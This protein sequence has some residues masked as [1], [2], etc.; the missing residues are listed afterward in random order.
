MLPSSGP[1]SLITDSRQARYA[2]IGRI[3]VARAPR[4][5]ALINPPT[6]RGLFHNEREMDLACQSTLRTQ[7]GPSGVS[8]GHRYP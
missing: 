3:C 2:T 6:E 5:K 8:T 7:A 1:M 4:E